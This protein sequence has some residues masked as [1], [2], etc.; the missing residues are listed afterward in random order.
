MWAIVLLPMIYHC[1][2]SELGRATRHREIIG[3]ELMRQG[4]CDII[5]ESSQAKLFPEHI[6]EHMSMKAEQARKIGNTIYE[7]V[8]L[9]M[10]D[11]DDLQKRS[12]TRDSDEIFEIAAN[13]RIRLSRD[14]QDRI[15]DAERFV[16]HVER[17]EKENIMSCKQVSPFP[18][19]SYLPR[20]SHLDSGS[21]LV[22]SSC[23]S[24]Y[25]L[26]ITIVLILLSHYKA[27]FV[28]Y[29]CVVHVF[30]DHC[31]Y[32]YYETDDLMVS[33]SN[34]SKEIQ[35]KKLI[36]PSAR[37]KFSET[38]SGHHPDKNISPKI[39]RRNIIL[40]IDRDSNGKIVHGA[41][42]NVTNTFTDKNVSNQGKSNKSLWINWN[43]ERQDD[44]QIFLSTSAAQIASFETWKLHRELYIE[45][46][47]QFIDKFSNHLSSITLV[48]CF[49]QMAVCLVLA[50]IV[51]N[52]S[53][54]LTGMFKS[55]HCTAFKY[56]VHKKFLFRNLNKLLFIV[57][58]LAALFYSDFNYRE[59]LT[60]DILRNLHEII[61]L[62]S[63]QAKLYKRDWIVVLWQNLERNIVDN[64][65]LHSLKLTRATMIDELE[66]YKKAWKRAT[67]CGKNSNS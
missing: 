54:F 57:I 7:V 5:K 63:E 23:L 11:F 20:S 47:E 58:T 46:L 2:A 8:G 32:A 41:R 27:F 31:H 52:I 22:L 51:P 26:S 55:A 28:R 6:D 62:E 60:G 38:G 29:R 42:K 61:L 36:L 15:C 9:H 12:L 65:I 64:N 1:F 34:L 49:L 19:A 16:P 56:L 39:D 48:S 37:P 14:L 67:N 33:S 59:Y 10:A 21:L 35:E 25:H 4:Y 43:Y 30:P 13:V 17:L 24:T 40:T 3:R 18:P 66:R 53:T 45:R 44:Q 50:I